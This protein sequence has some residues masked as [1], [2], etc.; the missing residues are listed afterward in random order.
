MVRLV[1]IALA[2]WT[3]SVSARADEPPRRFE[4]V[5]VSPA[6]IRL[7]GTNRRQQ[8]LVTAVAPAGNQASQQADQQVDQQA[9]QQAS[10][11]ASKQAGQ[12]AGQQVD[13]TRKVQLRVADPDLA[14][15]D[16]SLVT[17][18]ADGQTE[19]VVAFES[20]ETRVPLIVAGA[21]TFP[22]VHFGNDIVPLF[23][24]LRCNSAGCHGKQSGG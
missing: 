20:G 5:V 6:T 17:G 19:L 14:R 3:V 22:P 15:V 11:Q 13:V 23:S 16:G 2:L 8:V 12:Q 7:T 24:K 21:S 10:K 18:L 4:S 9:D 1:V